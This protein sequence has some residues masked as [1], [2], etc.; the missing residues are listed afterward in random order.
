[1]VEAAKDTASADLMS[2]LR[3]AQQNLADLQAFKD[4]LKKTNAQELME[5]GKE[6]E[7]NAGLSCMHV[8]CA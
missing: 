5:V 2:A 4:A 1:M 8:I 6:G 3:A 7:P